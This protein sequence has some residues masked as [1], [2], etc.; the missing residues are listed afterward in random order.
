M[1]IIYER[2]A[3]IDIGKKIIA[4]AVR[5]PDE[6]GGKRRQLVRKFD[7]YWRTLAEMAAWLV[8]EG[9]THV[10]MEATGIYWRPIFHALCE[11]QRPW[12]VL[13]VNEVPPR[14]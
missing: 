4:V 6:R 11:A 12:E 1:E 5:T 7:T 2:V 13:L 14:T 9:V 3:A 8:G 10:S